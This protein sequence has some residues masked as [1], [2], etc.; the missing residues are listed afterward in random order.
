MPD[1]Q[2]DDPLPHWVA[3]KGPHPY[4]LV[5]YWNLILAGITAAVVLINTLVT[6]PGISPTSEKWIN[7]A[8]AWIAALA[9]VL[10]D[11]QAKLIKGAEWREKVREEEAVDTPEEIVADALETQQAHK[12]T[13]D[14]IERVEPEMPYHMPHVQQVEEQAA[15]TEAEK[16]DE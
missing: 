10:K 3:T 9:L 16:E 13:E 14:L 11:S 8:A 2:S 1:D 6:I 12:P 15:P 4:W 5:Q 7:A